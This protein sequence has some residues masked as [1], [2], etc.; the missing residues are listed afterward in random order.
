MHEWFFRS[1]SKLAA[2]MFRKLNTLVI[3]TASQEQEFIQG[4]PK[5]AATTEIAT[6][7]L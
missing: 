3:L 2:S 4:I 5:Q 6:V 1:T 7:I